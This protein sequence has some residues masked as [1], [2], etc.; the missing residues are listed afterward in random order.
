[1]DRLL[2]PGPAR[3]GAMGI[4][5]LVAGVLLVVILRYFQNLEPV[6]ESSTLLFFGAIIGL[7]AALVG[8]G[9]FNPARIFA[10]EAG[11]PRA[12]SMGILGFLLGGLFVVV[13]RGLQGLEP[14]WNTGVGIIV[15]AF[16]TTGFFVWGMGAFDPRLSQHGEGHETPAT[17]DEDEADPATTLGSSIWQVSF[18]VTAILIVIAFFALVPGG[19]GLHITTN[20]DGSFFATGAV[21]VQLPFNGPEVV[22]SQLVIFILF[23]II[24]LISLAI[25]AGLIALVMTFLAQN[26]NQ[27]KSTEPTLADRTPPGVFR[28]LGRVSGAIAEWL[29]R[30]LP[31]ALGQR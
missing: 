12:V 31:K 9:V 23:A 14:L 4:L 29:R 28:F 5:G 25:I 6:W 20:P 24:V 21:T 19:P 10:G 27:V 22:V 8:L 11:L 2:K 15:M 1:L 17:H 7:S 18:Y 3:A 26:V 30:G 13:L 16:T